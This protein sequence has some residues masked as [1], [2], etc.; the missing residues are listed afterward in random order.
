[1]GSNCIFVSNPNSVLHTT[2]T[3]HKLRSNCADPC[4]EHIF[5]P[6]YNANK[7]KS[8]SGCNVIQLTVKANESLL[9]KYA[10]WDEDGGGG[11][12]VQVDFGETV[13]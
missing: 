6:T 1:M 3:Q 11:G 9:S 13:T 5:G 7:E 12:T 4:Q 2:F 8:M 10:N